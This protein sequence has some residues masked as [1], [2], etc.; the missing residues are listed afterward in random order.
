M[1]KAEGDVTQ[2][3]RRGKSNVTMGTEMGVIWP[4]NARSHQS[5]EK[6]GTD[7]SLEHSEHVHRPTP[8]FWHSETDLGLLD[9]RTVKE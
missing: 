2:T 4:R 9:S 1:R 6:Q 8:I 3:D 5:W 7:G